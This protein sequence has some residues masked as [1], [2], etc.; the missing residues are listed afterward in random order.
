[1]L[2]SGALR[3]RLH[4]VSCGVVLF[5]YFYLEPCIRRLDDKARRLRWEFAVEIVPRVRT[6]WA[7]NL[8]LTGR[9]HR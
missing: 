4:T 8:S 5:V 1:M 2:Q 6:L 7:L 9:R 3:P